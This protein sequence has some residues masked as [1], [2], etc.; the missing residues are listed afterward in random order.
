MT[1]WCWGQLWFADAWQRGADRDQIIPSFT[2]LS[3]AACGEGRGEAA[4]AALAFRTIRRPRYVPH[5]LRQI[6]MP[7]HLPDGAGFAD[8]KPVMVDVPKSA[9]RSLFPPYSDV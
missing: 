1:G 5:E 8:V 6:G 3:C 9:D 7:Q 2:A 4:N